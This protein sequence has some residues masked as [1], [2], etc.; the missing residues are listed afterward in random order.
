MNFGENIIDNI[1][2]GCLM[3]IYMCIYMYRA[4]PEQ[5]EGSVAQAAPL[6]FVLTDQ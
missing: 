5:H 3:G 4:L 2:A 1:A 6:C